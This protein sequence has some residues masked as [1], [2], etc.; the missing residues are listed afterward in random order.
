MEFAE[1][2]I[3]LYPEV[4]GG[5]TS[6]GNAAIEY[7]EKWG[8]LAT[9]DEMAHGKVWKY[10]YIEEMNVHELHIALAHK[11]DKKRLEAKLRKKTEG[12]ETHL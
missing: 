2:I 3:D 8:W 9:I 4:Y 11:N 6:E 1:G 10:E 5:G 7:F 12:I